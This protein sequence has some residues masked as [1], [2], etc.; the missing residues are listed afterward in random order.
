VKT[1]SGQAALSHLSNAKCKSFHRVPLSELPAEHYGAIYAD[2]PWQYDNKATRAAA[3]DHYQTMTVDKICELPVLE[4]AKKKAHLWL[5]TTNA[6][7]FESQRVLEAWGFEYKAVM[8]WVKPQMG[9]GN[10]V[11]VSHEFLVIGSRG[12][13]SGQ[14]TK[15]MSWIQHDRLKHSQKPEV[16]RR[17]VEDVSPGPYLELFARCES[18]GWHSWGD[19]VETRLL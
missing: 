10:Y 9:L 17:V 13:L 18:T 3:G 12:G 6:F 4:R 5:W 15:Q 14:S 2:P 19:Q 7:L 16:F 8:V 11:R 1:F